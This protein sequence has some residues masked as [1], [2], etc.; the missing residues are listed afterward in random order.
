MIEI[1]TWAW[2]VC[3]PPLIL[4]ALWHGGAALL[5]RTAPDEPW[6]LSH[7]SMTSLRRTMGDHLS[8]DSGLR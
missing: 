6:D 5:R 1:V 8:A 3:G 4:A 2:F 7:W